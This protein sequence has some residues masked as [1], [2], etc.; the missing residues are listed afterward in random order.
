[1]DSITAEN[2]DLSF[3]QIEINPGSSYAGH[4]L[5][6]TNILSE[7]NVIVVAIHRRNGE[8]TFN[9]TGDA[10][11]DAGDTLIAIGQA[12]A[13]MRMNDLARGAKE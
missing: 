7:L 3:E 2:L 9:P 11:I 1:M 4:K 13:L 10:M 5:R 12:E 6:F 8:R